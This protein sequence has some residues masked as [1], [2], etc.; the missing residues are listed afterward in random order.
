MTDPKKGKTH[1][2]NLY[3]FKEM[4]LGTKCKGAKIVK[5]FCFPTKRTSVKESG[6]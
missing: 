6:L 4:I 1:K 3:L 5:V 2:G